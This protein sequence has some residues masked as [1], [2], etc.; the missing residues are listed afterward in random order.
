MRDLNGNPYGYAVGFYYEFVEFDQ[1]H[2]LSYVGNGIKT[3]V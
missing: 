1:P 2:L 3:E